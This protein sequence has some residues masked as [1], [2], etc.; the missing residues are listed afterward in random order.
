[1]TDFMLSAEDTVRLLVW[2]RA[3]AARKAA[4]RSEDAKI[5]EPGSYK[6]RRRDGLPGAAPA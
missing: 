6:S 3:E 1:M 5:S 4:E 2:A